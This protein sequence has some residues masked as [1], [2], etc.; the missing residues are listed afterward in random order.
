M[1]TF[2]KYWD[3]FGTFLIQNIVVKRF[4]K[5]LYKNGVMENVVFFTAPVVLPCVCQTELGLT[6]TDVMTPF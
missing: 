5:W 4:V 2:W 1:M 6:V 3:K